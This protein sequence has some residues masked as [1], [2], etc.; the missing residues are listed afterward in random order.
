M[1]GWSSLARHGTWTASVTVMGR[2]AALSYTHVNNNP[3]RIRG[4]RLRCVC[5][6][7]DVHSRPIRICRVVAERTSY[8][9]KIHRR[10]RFLPQQVCGRTVRIPESA[11]LPRAGS[12][13]RRWIRRLGCGRSACVGRTEVVLCR[14]RFLF[15]LSAPTLALLIMAFGLFLYVPILLAVGMVPLMLRYSLAGPPARDDNFVHGWLGVLGLQLEQ[16]ARLA[17]GTSL[18]PRAAQRAFYLSWVP[19]GC[20]CL[21]FVVAVVINGVTG[22]SS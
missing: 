13:H 20:G 14:L 5:Q 12:L 3:P 6:Q 16:V 7:K 1:E 8:Q 15:A 11:R 10:R 19:F 2:S 18:S 9:V 17:R 21:F 22:S 4:S